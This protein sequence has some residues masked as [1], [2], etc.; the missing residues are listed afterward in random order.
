[1]VL[2]VPSSQVARKWMQAFAAPSVNAAR[3]VLL[4]EGYLLK[5]QPFGA[6]DKTR[7]FRITTTAFTYY[8][9]EAGEEM[10]ST[11]FDTVMQVT[12]SANGRDFMVCA[13]VFS[14]LS[15]SCFVVTHAN[16]F[17]FLS[18]CRVCSRLQR[19]GRLRCTA[20]AR[21]RRSATNGLVL[22]GGR[23]QPPNLY[24]SNYSPQRVY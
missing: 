22:C 24:K 12:L 1:M 15:L 10:G 21:A 4:A 20:A 11:T 3:G 7:W 19:P 14:S 2:E 23:C 9:N 18:R 8:T 13:R 17:F 5:L 16:S 6:S